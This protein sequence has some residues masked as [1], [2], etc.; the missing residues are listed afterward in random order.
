MIA[1][2]FSITPISNSPGLS[3]LGLEIEDSVQFP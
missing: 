3:V 2:L 1:I